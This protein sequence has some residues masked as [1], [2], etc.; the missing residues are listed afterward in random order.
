MRKLVALICVVAWAGFWAFGYLAL[1]AGVSD[2]R[3]AVIAGLLA[4]AGFISGSFAYMKLAR[5]DL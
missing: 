3:Q 4:A 5:G 2:N 1:S